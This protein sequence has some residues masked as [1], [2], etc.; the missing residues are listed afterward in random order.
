M[1]ISIA[2]LIDTNGNLLLPPHPSHMVIMDG[3]ANQTYRLTEIENLAMA[4]IEYINTPKMIELKEKKIEFK[5]II[6]EG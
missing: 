2:R 4:Q 3:K 1:K 6:K 5:E